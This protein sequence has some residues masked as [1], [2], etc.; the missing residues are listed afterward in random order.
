MN[1]VSYYEDDLKSES[2]IKLMIVI[3]ISDLN[4]SEL[5]RQGLIERISD[6]EHQ[7]SDRTR[8]LEVYQAVT[9]AINRQLELQKVLQMIADNAR[10]LTNTQAATVYLLEK[11]VLRL[12]VVSGTLPV[13]VPVGFTMPLE[14]SVAGLAIRDRKPYCVLDAAHDERVYMEAVR[15]SSIKSFLIVP[16]FSG[17]TA[18]GVISVAD[19]LIGVL[20]AE[21]ERILSLLAA[22]VVISLENARL[23][24]Q[25]AETAVVVERNRLAR[26]LHDAVTQSL[27][28][29]SL[30][31]DVLP[32]I[33]KENPT[34]GERRLEELRRLSKGALAEMRS[35]LLELRPTALEEA[36][37][38]DLLRHLSNAFTG[39][40]Q[41]PVQL[42]LDSAV[43]L[44]VVVKIGFYRIAQEAFNNIAKHAEAENVLLRLQKEND[45]VIL[46]IL[47]DGQ[48][49]NPEEIPEGHLGVKIMRERAE[50]I[51]ACLEISSTPGEG[52]R[53]L[54]TWND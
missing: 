25:A 3:S 31:A 22:N 20:G 35:L 48:G 19:K 15:R 53:L 37:L 52:T 13:S 41:I 26:E 43:V 27:F 10:L 17:D 11:D 23:Y 21:D 9:Q 16:L 5:T 47:D 46:E 24:A 6:L 8:E 33:W 50:S 2:W 45:R 32:R 49:F 44:P 7:L 18:L 38:P 29:A 34:E 30:I 42:V 1:F 4:S 54:L 28:S 36:A 14:H 51:N 12:A 40:T 39:K